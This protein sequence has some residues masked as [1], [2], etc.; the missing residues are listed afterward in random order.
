[1]RDSF[2]TVYGRIGSCHQSYL[3]KLA[4]SHSQESLNNSR[5]HDQLCKE[6]GVDKDAAGKIDHYGGLLLLPAR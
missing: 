3:E 4:H 5:E 1:M 2:G 6:Q